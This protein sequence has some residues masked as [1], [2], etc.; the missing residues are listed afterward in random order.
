V[1][2]GL[3][4]GIAS[5]KSTVAGMFRELG[6]TV[7]NADDEGRAVVAP[8]EPALAELVAAFGPEYLRP[9]G[10]LD[11]AKL[12]ARIF[13]RRSDRLLLNRITH[14]RIADR[15]RQKLYG[16]QGTPPR[17]PV[18]VIEA[19]ILLEAG[20]GRFVD[21]IVVVAAQ[22]TTQMARLIA[23]HGLT[24]EGA[25]R[26]IRSQI[27]LAERLRHADYRINGELALDQ[28]RREVR[29]VWSDLLDLSTEFGRGSP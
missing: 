9:D 22:Q 18:V 24:S 25:E 28:T 20:W 17:P 14:P 26:R 29:A 6:A 23:D 4:G 1:V 27:T 19:A 15:L 16:F 11:R 5:G 13:A 2:A 21:R 10:T 7:L 12:G 3:T 8:G